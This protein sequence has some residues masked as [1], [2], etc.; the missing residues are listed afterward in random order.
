MPM[1][2]IT[3][4]LAPADLRKEGPSYDLPMAVALLTASE[5]L[6]LEP[7]QHLFLGELGLDGALR[8][9]TGIL[10]MVALARE[11]AIPTVSVPAVIHV[12]HTPGDMLNLVG[13]GHL[14]RISSGTIGQVLTIRPDGLPRWSPSRGETCLCALKREAYARAGNV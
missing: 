10:P 1:R 9:T 11:R 5:Q 8:H 13:S 12:A 3:V 6:A 14:V 4:N 2:R 7:A